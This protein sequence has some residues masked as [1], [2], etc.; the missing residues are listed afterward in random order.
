MKNVVKKYNKPGEEHVVIA[1]SNKGEE[2]NWLGIIDAR[3]KGNYSLSVEAIHREGE[4]RGKITVRGVVG[5]GAVVKVRG[6][7]KIEKNAQKVDDF[8]E[9]RLLLIDPTAR[10][11]ADPQLEI[12]ADNVK[13]SHAASV[14]RI[15]EEQIL[16]LMSRG[17]SMNEAKETIIQGFLQI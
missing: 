14:G 5:K 2:K 10:A 8:L 17:M 3:E 1:I 4:N 6:L 12:E 9:I 11:T 13:A 7:I 15:D 16:Y